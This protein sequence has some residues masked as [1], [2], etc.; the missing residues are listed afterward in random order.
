MQGRSKRHQVQRAS[1]GDGVPGQLAP[2]EA[3]VAEAAVGSVVHY[4][5]RR[6]ARQRD[7]ST[8]TATRSE[9]LQALQRSNTRCIYMYNIYIYM[10]IYIYMAMSFLLAN[11]SLITRDPT[12]KHLNE[13]SCLQH[14]QKLQNINYTIYT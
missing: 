14:F 2:R 3:P 13:L 1:S 6:D 12:E 10:Y 5:Q 11:K 9:R 7:L 8:L 4:R